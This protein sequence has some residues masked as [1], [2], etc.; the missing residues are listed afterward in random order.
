MWDREFHCPHPGCAAFCPVWHPLRETTFPRL[1]APSLG[2]HYRLKQGFLV[3]RAYAG[4]DL[5]FD[6][7]VQHVLFIPTNGLWPP[8]GRPGHRHLS[9]PP[10]IPRSTAHPSLFPPV[11]RLATRPCL[12]RCLLLLL[13][14]L[15]VLNLLTLWRAI[16]LTADPHSLSPLCSVAHSPLSRRLQEN[17]AFSFPFGAEPLSSLHLQEAVNA[18][19]D[20]VRDIGR[21]TCTHAR[22]AWSDFME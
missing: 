15:P 5:T 9:C 7:R 13:V 20:R 11:F 22:S 4:E 18:F 16:A 19:L 10:P 2:E 8:V 12:S 6:D 1:P 21:R 3:Q 17:P 14:P